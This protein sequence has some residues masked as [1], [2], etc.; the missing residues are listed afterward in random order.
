[1]VGYFGFERTVVG[2]KKILSP[3]LII[4][5]F[6]TT[7]INTIMVSANINYTAHSVLIEN[8][9]S[10]PNLTGG[11]IT[12]SDTTI[13]ASNYNYELDYMGWTDTWR[14][15]FLFFTENNGTK[16]QF[17]TSANA[18][19]IINMEY[20]VINTAGN[21]DWGL[22]V[23]LFGGILANGV[24]SNETSMRL[25]DYIKYQTA[26]RGKTFTYT[27]IFTA[28]SAHNIGLQFAGYGS[29]NI[30][31][32]NILELPAN[33]VNDYV[34]VTYVDGEDI[35][36][37]FVAKN[38][39]LKIPVKEYYIFDGWYENKECSGEAV[40]TATADITLYAKWDTDINHTAHSVLIENISSPSNLIG[41]NITLSDTTITASNYNYELDYM[42]WTDT[43]RPTF[44][45]FTENNG[46][47]TQFTTS[48]NAKYII[49]MEYTVINT[50]GNEDWG[51]Q[52]GLFG[53]ILANGVTSNETSMRLNDYIKYQTADR[54]KTFT[55]TAIFTAASAHNIGLQFA[56]YGS[57]NIKSINILEL[58][59]NKVNDYV[60]VT[61]VDGEDIIGEFVAKN[62]ELKIPVKEYYI[63]G[64][65]YENKECSGEAVTTAASDIILYAKWDTDDNIVVI[66]FHEGD[67]N[68]I[69]KY[70]VGDVIDRIPSIEGYNFLGWYKYDSYIGRPVTI[71]ADGLTDLYAKLEEQNPDVETV[72]DLTKNETMVTT[73]KTAASNMKLNNGKLIFDI[74]NYE[75]QL[76][77]TDTTNSDSWFPA[78]YFNDSEGNIIDLQ[79]GSTYELAVAYKIIDV[80]AGDNIGLQIGFGAD[81]QPNQSRTRIKG[82]AVHK[83]ED[84]GKEFTYTTSYTAEKFNFG[85]LHLPKLLFSG[86]GELEVLSIKIKKILPVIK[87]TVIGMQTYEDYEVGNDVGV[88]GN[89]KGTE[90]SNDVNYT[91]GLFSNKSLKLTL[92]TNFLRMSGNTIIS[93]E[94][95]GE[96][97]P[98]A[99][100]KGAAYRVT[101]Y[102][103]ANEDIKELVWSIN[104][105]GET[106]KGD[107]LENFQLEIQ[108]KVSLDKGEWKKITAY[109]PVLKGCSS[110]E[111]LLAIAV[112]SNGYDGKAVYIDDVKV[113]QLLDSEVLLYNTM[114]GSELKPQRAYKGKKYLSF[115]EPTK[116]G[117]LFD[118]W[119]YDTEYKEEAK[120]SDK[121]PE[122]KT[123]ITLYAKW[124]ETPT[125]AY[126]FTA[127]SFD[128]EIYNGDIEPYENNIT[129]M[130]SSVDCENNKG[131]TQNA[132]WVIDAG[133]YGNGTAETDGAL[134]F[135]NELYSS[136]NDTQG[137]NAVRLV[138]ED[139][140]PFIVVK[141][142]R[143]TLQFDYIFASNKG[144]SY[145]IP[146]ISECSAYTDIGYNSFH[147]LG[148]VSVMETDTD[149]LTYRQSFIA[150]RTGYVYL[151]LTGR[152]DNPNVDTHC[153][154]KVCVDNVKIELNS[155]VVKLSINNGNTTWYTEYGLKGEKLILPNAVKEGS[156]TFDGF[157]LDSEFK[158]KFNGFFPENDTTI[159]VKLKKD[160]YDTPSDFSKPIVL[161][162]EETELLDVFY[163]QQKYMTS[164]SREVQN[165]WIFVADDADNALNGE[166]YIKLNGFSHYWNQAKFALYDPNHPENVMLLDKGAK[167]RV[168]VMVRC[169]DMY[170]FPVNMTICLENPASRYLLEENG[171]IKLEYY[172]AGDRDG[173]YMFVGDIEVSSDMT[174]Y[175]S[176]AIRRNAN[177]LQS[178]FID[179]VSVEKLKNV[180]VKFE[181]NGGT[182]VEDAVIQIHD[183]VYDPGTPYREG[184]VFDGWYADSSFSVKWD[185]DNDTVENDMIL[186]AKW[187]VQ[188]IE[189]EESENEISDDTLDI[190]NNETVDNGKAPNLIEAD[191]V[192]IDRGVD[193]N[194]VNPTN[195]MSVVT[196]IL[197]CI[198]SLLFLAAVL[199][200]IIISIRKFLR[201]RKAE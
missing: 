84:I 56:G 120:L 80:K 152:D 184:F 192:V 145:I 30:K 101:F 20:T 119:Y 60:A 185:F 44:L 2:V 19:Y 164:W 47:K 176:L 103:Y 118:G 183:L 12:L 54:G 191:K 34:A 26:D 74:Y 177:D 153:Y 77:T 7:I 90:V 93:L 108:D 138:N 162:F 122:D 51:L 105:V 115:K 127:G 123:E 73:E 128:K 132:A 39:E 66:N 96:L 146:V 188:A 10:S 91:S 116:A 148:K 88:L 140:T 157:Y 92:D 29:M 130:D 182:S 50:A 187:S 200:V 43:W 41:G 8:I 136:Y 87:D 6:L 167:Y 86:Q 49:N 161:D 67:S 165:E 194:S 23:G 25:N 175:P 53:G 196:I 110:W 28:A 124:L 170:D 89:K 82:Y 121:F 147:T 94:Q 14:P 98:Y 33:K 156:D 15:T 141:G 158:T 31:S 97:K 46:T 83:K 64:G 4:A 40:T 9:S 131:M 150:E 70:T 76:N 42:G 135:S 189:D 107:Y 3:V 72:V 181:E 193:N 11:N 199:F 85:Q 197:I 112:A 166:N 186:Y 195:S 201:K 59:A 79:I 27:A 61:Y 160:S 114:G 100:E 126:N 69:E 95:D 155:D 21:E 173:Y 24:T 144:L 159:Y 172:P 106:L 58:P 174:Y 22:Q 154:E 143:Y 109:I 81:G 48:A 190:N 104:S 57:M 13:T 142:E 68:V 102:M 137:Y 125:K 111:N 113:E 151:T 168:T 45:F 16:T 163:S 117:Y 32:I 5:M 62:G 75:R 133:I 18:K 171:N 180:T 178:I 35:I 55:Y 36:G 71:A 78:Y 149:Y 139:G 52:V 38:G 198:G 134:V 169:E 1:M 63:F 99:A 65:W 17:T 179:A 37:E 129:D